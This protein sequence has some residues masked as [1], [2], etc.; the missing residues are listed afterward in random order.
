MLS[1]HNLYH[2]EY[3]CHKVAIMKN[4][5]IYICDTMDS[6]RKKLGK[7]EYEVIFKADAAL[8]YDKQGDNYIFK[9]TEVSQIASLLQNI[10]DKNWALIDLSVQQSAL[11]DMY[12]KLMEEKSG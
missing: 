10:S 7:R 1:A 4:G 9:S 11:E 3:I 5:R 6:I 8:N 2:I 12:I